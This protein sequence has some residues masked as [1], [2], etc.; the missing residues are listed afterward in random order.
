MN[1]ALLQD[2]LRLRRAGKLAQAAELYGEV[3]RSEPK[4]FEALH[5][6]GIIH[7]QGGRLEEAERLIREASSVNPNAADAAYNHACLLQRLNRWEEALASFDR[8]LATRPDYLEALVNRGA[9]LSMLRRYD[10]ALANSDHVMRL[11]PNLA[12]AW[13][14]RGG[15][16]QAL[17]RIEEALAAYDRALALKPNYAEAAKSC[18]VLLMLLQRHEAALEAADR[19]L[20]FAANDS[21]LL[22]RRADLLALL[23]RTHEAAAAYEQYLLLKPDDAQAWRARGFALQ[24]LKRRPEA[25]SCFD[26]ALELAP[27]N[28]ELRASRAN[29]LFEVERFEAAA[30]D[31]EILLADDSAPAWVR[32]YLTICRLHCCDWRFLAEERPKIAADLEA[33]RFVVDPTGN[34]FISHSLKEQL[35]CARIWA[36]ERYPTAASLWGGERYRHDKIRLAYLSADFRTHATAFLMAG[37]FEHHDKSRFETAAFSYSADDKSPMRARLMR[38]F[39]SFIDVQTKSD[40]EVARLLGDM[41][42]DV[43]IDLKGYTAEGRPGIL[44]HRPA[45][46]SAHYLGFPGTMGVDYV[47]YL[48]ADPV[49]IPEEHQAFYTEQIAYLPDT[50]QCNDRERRVPE[51][52]PTRFQA[53]LPPGFVFCC[54]NNNHKIAPEIFEIWMRLLRGVEGSVLWLLQDNAA[55]AGNL[56]REARARGIAP[57]RL[58]FASRTDPAGHLARQSL[59]DLF[60]DT[61]PYNAHTTASDALWAGLPLLTVLG[62]TFA[63]RVAAS[64]LHAAGLP[65]LVTSSLAEYESLALRFARDPS[66]LALVKAKLRNNRDTCP[67]FDTE[68]MTRN[69]EAAYTTMWERYQ[70]GL[71]PATFAVPGALPP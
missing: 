10:E 30:R 51:R 41:E 21:A 15:V 2:A 1:E 68:R 16:L 48:I 64:L 11:K 46:V 28:R 65:E 40:E 67:L 29:M 7:Y 55:V 52:V 31:Y 9:V 70:R 25:L 37:I 27:N 71:R 57:E 50:Y 63:G 38:A 4:H 19:A 22:G 12:E 58:I 8:A 20:S 43:A 59:A 56:K 39:D 36:G 42:I 23:K 60:L 6:L 13:N 5:A 69:L 54:F 44:S 47:D 18:C 14:N 35:S 17:E 26:R 32:G 49:I 33:G 24:M 53:G 62:S 61:L 45:P 34:A 3:L 66:A